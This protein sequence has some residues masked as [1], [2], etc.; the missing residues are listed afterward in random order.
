MVAVVLTVALAVLSVSMLGWVA[1]GGKR[2]AVEA[3]R[4]QAL[5]LAESGV[6]EALYRL[7]GR[8]LVPP[9]PGGQVEFS[10]GDALG[11][12]KG[13]Y[14]VV[15]SRASEGGLD[16][17]STGVVGDASRRLTVR[18]RL[19]SLVPAEI[20][21]PGPKG[22][23]VRATD[24]QDPH[25]D[26]GLYPPLID[27]R[28]PPLPSPVTRWDYRGSLGTGTHVFDC[29]DVPKQ[30]SLEIRADGPVDVYV[31]GF[32]SVGNKAELRCVG[33]GPVRFYVYGDPA[34]PQG[35]ALYLDSQ[36]AVHSEGPTVWT[37]N[38]GVLLDQHAR[39]TQGSA[40]AP[41]ALN[42]RGSLLVEGHAELGSQ[43]DEGEAPRVLVV[44]E[45]SGTATA[46]ELEQH[47]TVYAMIYAPD[48]DVNMEEHS[49][50]AGAL[51]CHRLVLEK[52]A[53][54]RWNEGIG[55]LTD[56]SGWELLAGWWEVETG[57]WSAR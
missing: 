19:Q 42:I 49:L 25:Y 32:V 46:L 7:N 57:T 53:E 8:S 44:L 1:S 37:I 6:A 17:E 45:P 12:G 54:C 5:Y 4:A 2:V 48:A 51:V 14:Q 24:A 56:S 10:S 35:Q 39:F 23:G 47:A 38:G 26:P 29:I 18:L 22:D 21:S 36:A 27:F 43:P 55:D 11:W 13:S 40:D 16:V 41:A 30:G 31:A 9:A 33:P 34:G 28:M 50:L 15:V 52:Q 20:F 3:G